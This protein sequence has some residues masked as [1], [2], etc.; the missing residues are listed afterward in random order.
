MRAFD[1]PQWCDWEKEWWNDFPRWSILNCWPRIVLERESKAWV[2]PADAK[3]CMQLQQASVLH[4]ELTSPAKYIQWHRVIENFCSCVLWKNPITAVCLSVY[5]LYFTFFL[6]VKRAFIISIKPRDFISKG[7][8][9][10]CNI[11]SNVSTCMISKWCLS[12]LSGGKI[13]KINKQP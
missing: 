10:C 3:W 8:K 5:L 4:N 12:V 1:A 13:W 11:I 6:C 7:K 2:M 9:L